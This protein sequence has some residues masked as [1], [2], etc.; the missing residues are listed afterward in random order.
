MKFMQPKKLITWDA[1]GIPRPHTEWLLPKNKI[2]D[3]IL[4]SFALPYEGTYNDRL[5]QIVLEPEYEGLTNIEVACI[6]QAKKAASG[7]LEALRFTIERI[8][9]KPKQAVEQTTVTMSLKEYLSTIDIGEI[10]DAVAVENM[11]KHIN[12]EKDMPKHI[13]FDTDWMDV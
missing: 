8:L 11:P 3:V 13:E 5:E 7:D 6:K 1:N 9:G 10:V 4:A 2:D 12:E